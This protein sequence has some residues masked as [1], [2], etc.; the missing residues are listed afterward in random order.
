MRGNWQPRDNLDSLTRY[1]SGQGASAPSSEFPKHGMDDQHHHSQ[2][3][4]RCHSE[5]RS[6]RK[7]GASESPARHDQRQQRVVPP[8]QGGHTR[9]MGTGGGPPQERS[10]KRRCFS[11]PR[12]R[13]LLSPQTSSSDDWAC[14]GGRPPLR[15]RQDLFLGASPERPAGISTMLADSPHSY[16]ATASGPFWRTCPEEGFV[17]G[18]FGRDCRFTAGERF[19]SM[20]Q[21]GDPLRL[22]STRP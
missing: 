13:V 12:E 22:R 19:G 21:S 6:S 10:A 3:R 17:H 4:H 18:H 8:P 5:Q 14:F 1:R 20:E 15:H 16:R 2:G 11:T 7:R 9:H